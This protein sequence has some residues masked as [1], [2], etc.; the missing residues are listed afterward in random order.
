[1]SE[2]DQRMLCPDGGCVGV[3]G[4]D[5]TCKVCGRAA[6]NWGDERARGLAHEGDDEDED[7]VEEDED[8]DED[9]AEGD[10]REGDA[11]APSRGG[12]VWTERSLCPDGACIGVIG[13][14]GTCKV[15]GRAAEDGDE[16]DDEGDL[17]EDSD[18]ND[19]D[20]AR[21]ESDDDESDHDESDESESESD[22]DDDDDDESES[23]DDESES[24]ES[25]SDESESDDERPAAASAASAA[26]PHQP[27]ADR[28]CPT[29]GCAGKIGLL[30]RCNSCGKEAAA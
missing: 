29:P 8:E 5:G 20:E 3:I 15:C 9:V 13:D 14:D 25:E 16:G 22:D 28:S 21:D 17:D 6:P 30:N 18:E 10:V 4:A 2:W 1:M 26:A 24:D 11:R 27:S 19:D 7:D 23:D 12:E